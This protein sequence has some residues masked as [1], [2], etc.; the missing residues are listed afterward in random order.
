MSDPDDRGLVGTL[1]DE[2]ERVR[3]IQFDSIHKSDMAWK[4]F[5]GQMLELRRYYV[6]EGAIFTDEPGLDP[7]AYF[8]VSPNAIGVGHY[9]YRA[10]GINSAE[11]ACQETG[12]TCSM[13]YAA[14]AT[15][16]ASNVGL[17]MAILDHRK[18]GERSRK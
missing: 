16:I 6:G 18:A 3:A 10:Y 13:D 9:V 17:Y 14:A 4:V 12:S 15:E 5:H 7:E 1:I 8:G 2:A 11:R